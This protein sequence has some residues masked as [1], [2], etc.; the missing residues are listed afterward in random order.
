MTS[1]EPDWPGTRAVIFDVDGTLYDQRRLRIKMAL[2]LARSCL[3]R[4]SGWKELLVIRTFRRT[5]AGLAGG[6]VQN[7]A[8]AQY[9]ACARKLGIAP[10][11]V[12]HIIE[13]WMFRAPLRHLGACR[14]PGVR[15]FMLL[16]KARG[17]KTGVFSDY[18][19]REK[20][21]ALDLH[22]DVVLA[23]TDPEVDR[24][25]PDP[26]GL[27]LTARRLGIPAR[28][29]LYIGDR[30][31]LDGA[32]ARSAGM[33]CLIFAPRVRGRNDRF[34]DYGRLIELLRAWK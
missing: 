8:A 33:G 13:K 30:D 29:C 4:P 7:L 10:R 18:P 14:R 25:K 6:E 23:A 5:R 15:D 12:E 32:A 28:E 22:P 11:Q 3:F 2:D 17:I 26:K 20:L 9:Q 31:D 19:A 16:L 21:E 27:I 24:L 1:A 34:Q